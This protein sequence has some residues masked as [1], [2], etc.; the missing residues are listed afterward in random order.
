MN[1]LCEWYRLG[2][3]MGPEY[4]RAFNGVVLSFHIKEERFELIDSPPYMDYVMNRVCVNWTRSRTA[5][6]TFTM[7]QPRY[8]YMEATRR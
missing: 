1:G 2:F 5:F 6:N 4:E 8:A 7:M 3:R